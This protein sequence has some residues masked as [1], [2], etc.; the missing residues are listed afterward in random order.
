LSSVE[1]DRQ[2]RNEEVIMMRVRCVLFGSVLMLVTMSSHVWA[3]GLPDVLGI[4]L[5]MP[6]REAHAKLQGQFPKNNLQVM[7]TNLPT[8]EKPVITSFQSTPKQTLAMGDEGD[9]VTVDVTL[10]P[11]KQAVWRVAREHFFPNKGI[12]RKTLLASLREKYGKES[13]AMASNGKAATDESHIVGL[14]WLMDE[15]GR[16]ATLPPLVG[17]TDPLSSCKGYTEG[18]GAGLVE[19]PPPTTFASADYKWCLSNY[20]AVK[21]TLMDSELPELYSRMI[22]GV[23]S[24]PFAARAGEATMKWKKDIAEGQHKQELEKAKQQD[25]PKL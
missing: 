10:P 19:S 15:Q 3:D 17:M 12:P 20:T 23:V 13:R 2:R 9:I 18:G 8:I 16:P 7:S 25:K 5:G 14:L 6:A 22:I 21:V 11:N 4:Q 1:R 24:V